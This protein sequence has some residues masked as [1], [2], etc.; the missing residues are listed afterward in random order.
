MNEPRVTAEEYLKLPYTRLLIPDKESGTFTAEIVEFPGCIAQGN[1]AEEAYESLEK[2]AK[3][4]IEA[5]LDLGQQVP[6]P[7]IEERYSGRFALRLPKSLH[8]QA[9]MAADMEGI[10]L[11]QFIVYAVSEKV[12]VLK[13]YDAIA[14]KL[15]KRID[16]HQDR[17]QTA[18]TTVFRQIEYAIEQQ[19]DTSHAQ[20]KYV[21]PMIIEG[22][23]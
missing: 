18:V 21:M 1:T 9:S 23:H 4:W 14:Q 5:S 13:L 19:A 12:G 2:V 7:M 10:S 8:R 20:R 22:M 3:S 16:L 11:N 6:S 15:I 17:I